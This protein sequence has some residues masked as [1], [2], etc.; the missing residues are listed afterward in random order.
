MAPN[1][2]SYTNPLFDSSSINNSYFNIND[3]DIKFDET[4]HL[5]INNHPNPQYLYV[6]EDLK[7]KQ[8]IGNI[9]SNSSTENPYSENSIYKDYAIY[10]GVAHKFVKNIK[11]EDYI[12]K[13]L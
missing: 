9:V 1:N 6:Y 7:G 13:A 10:V 4:K 5:W 3:I 12:I 11:P 8:I 2:N